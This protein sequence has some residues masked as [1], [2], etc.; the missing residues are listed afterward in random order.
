MNTFL[1]KNLVL[2]GN[3]RDSQLYDLQ[4]KAFSESSIHI[5]ER[6]GAFVYGN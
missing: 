3:W 5:I 2:H 6:D 4:Q 1:P